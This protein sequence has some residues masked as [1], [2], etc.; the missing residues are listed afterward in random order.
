M[1]K[2]N[3]RSDQ[4]NR[5][6]LNRVSS[7]GFAVANFSKIADELPSGQYN[8]KAIAY[9]VKL[10]DWR[11]YVYLHN[12]KDRPRALLELSFYLGKDMNKIWPIVGQ[13][14]VETEPG[15]AIVEWSTI[16]RT[17]Y[18]ERS[19]AM[20]ERERKDLAAMPENFDVWRAG[21]PGDMENVLSWTDS[22][23]RVYSAAC[24]FASVGNPAQAQFG[25][26]EKSKVLAFFSRN[27]RSE[28]LALPSDVDIFGYRPVRVKPVVSYSQWKKGD[29]W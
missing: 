9:A 11:S 21:I 18:G 3:N 22:E 5:S 6:V 25:K 24:K 16:W 10:E 26:L 7:M 19:L 17:A 14:W 2:R 20:T 1:T 8:D 13:L 29:G 23:E 12:P 28:F 4:G 15:E 27:G